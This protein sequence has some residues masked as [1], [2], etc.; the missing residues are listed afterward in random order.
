MCKC[1]SVSHGCSSQS[2]VAAYNIYAKQVV[3]SMTMVKVHD[4]KECTGG[5]TD[6]GKKTKYACMQA[7]LDSSSCKFADYA[8]QG[9]TRPPRPH[10][11]SHS[12]LFWF[13]FIFMILLFFCTVLV[14]P[15]CSATVPVQ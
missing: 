5:E 2:S 10:A 11:L 7:C 15:S 14:V 3:K 12:G 8:E 13:F 9:K 4:G 1:F 6:V